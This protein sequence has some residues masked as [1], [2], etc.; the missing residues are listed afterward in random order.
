MKE[1]QYFFPC[2]LKI[3]K[4]GYFKY[5]IPSFRSR[6]VLSIF[7][8]Y[9]WIYFRRY[10][11]IMYLDIGVCKACFPTFYCLAW[12]THWILQL[13]GNIKKKKGELISNIKRK[14]QFQICTQCPVNIHWESKGWCESSKQ[15]YA[16]LNKHTRQFLYLQQSFCKIFLS[17]TYAALKTWLD[18]SW[19]Y[20]YW[21]QIIVF[22]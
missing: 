10:L 13:F 6:E 11:L 4:L 5:F 7:K 8:P 19:E 2:I 15:S 3:T 14:L 1:T 22:W 18:T 16:P 9:R 12:A 20:S 17:M 21:S